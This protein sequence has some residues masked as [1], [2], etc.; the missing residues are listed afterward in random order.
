MRPVDGIQPAYVDL[1]PVGT[2]NHARTDAQRVRTVRRPAGERTRPVRSCE[3][4]TI[5]YVGPIDDCHAVYV[6]DASEGILVLLRYLDC[7]FG[8]VGEALMRCVVRSGIGCVCDADPF[9]GHFGHTYGD[10]V[11]LASSMYLWTGAIRM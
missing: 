6:L 8:I 5:S 7:R 10:G 9:E 11:G 1:S 2:E 3:V 4:V